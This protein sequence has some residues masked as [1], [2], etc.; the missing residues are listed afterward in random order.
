MTHRDDGWTIRGWITMANASHHFDSYKVYIIE[1][2]DNHE[3]FIKI[4]RTFCTVERRFS[5]I[6]A[7]PYN[8]K[9]LHLIE[10]ENPI[11]IYKL[12][13]KIKR[14]LK[15]Y[16]YNPRLKFDGHKECFSLDILTQEIIKKY[17]NL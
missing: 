15:P 4:G 17:V 6:G 9:I 7:M 12:E 13:N 3:R 5:E 10:D 1:C 11:H 8:Y 14:I 16:K 2:F